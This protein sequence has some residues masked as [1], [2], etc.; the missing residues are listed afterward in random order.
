VNRL[1][2][3][4]LGLV[5]ALVLAGLGARGWWL[6]GLQPLG[7]GEPRLFEVRTGSGVA[8]VGRELA[9]AGLIRSARVFRSRARRR[10]VARRLQAGVY[11]L[12]PSMAVDTMLDKLV[13]G[14][15]ALRNV[16]FPEGFTLTQCAERAQTAGFASAAQ[17]RELATRQAASFGL[18]G[19]PPGATLE[20]YLF[21]D[22][23]RLRPDAGARE[24][25]AAQ[26]KRFVEVWREL[27]AKPVT[28]RRERHAVVTIAAMVEAEAR[29]DDERARIAGVIE[30][31]L[32][33]NMRLQIDATVLYALGYHKSR[34]THAD[35][36]VDSP[37]NTYRVKGLP[38]GPIANPGKPSLAAALAPESHGYLFYVY[39]ASGRH[40][41]T[42]SAA[43][44]DQA[45]A[46]ARRASKKE[47]P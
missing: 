46:A 17:Y 32:A 19:L 39:G 38:P 28:N 33:R 31:R 15:V 5:L 25:I 3:I 42:R 8:A 22:T 16:T 11:E 24:L 47:R 12:A 9:E 34:V 10:G 35:L 29:A 26:V 40:V 6:R 43:E 18:Q 45:V 2:A 27:T 4:V 41:F 36:Q 7:A 20:G 30:N 14:D 37:Y 1:R 13:A 44:H 23:Y 21:P